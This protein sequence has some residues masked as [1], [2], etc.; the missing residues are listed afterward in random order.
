ETDQHRASQIRVERDAPQGDCNSRI[1]R[2]PESRRSRALREVSEPG[3][4]GCR[5]G[6]RVDGVG[7]GSDRFASRGATAVLGL[8]LRASR[9][10]CCVR[11]RRRR[12]QLRGRD[13]DGPGPAHRLLRN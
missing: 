12:L 6:R 13:E 9:R 2:T 1:R 3:R 7:E 11:R 4:H 10:R 8:L 5:I